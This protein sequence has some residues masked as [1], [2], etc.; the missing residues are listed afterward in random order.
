MLPVWTGGT[1]QFMKLAP[2]GFFLTKGYLDFCCDCS[3][4][5]LPP[6]GQAFPRPEGYPPKPL[7]GSI[8]GAALH[9]AISLSK[10]FILLHEFLCSFHSVLSLSMPYNNVLTD[11]K[12][13]GTRSPVPFHSHRALN[14]VVTVWEPEPVGMDMGFGGS[15][16]SVGTHLLN[17]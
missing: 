16:H 8:A 14:G 15:R 9:L 1:G 13:Q 4:H 12:I 2:F 11:W 17:Y 7:Q 5:I 10:A 6:C 3:M